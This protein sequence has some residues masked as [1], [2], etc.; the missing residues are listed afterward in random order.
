[1]SNQIPSIKQQIDSLTTCSDKKKYW[2]ET[3]LN[4]AIQQLN[5]FKFVDLHTHLGRSY[6]SYLPKLFLF[7]SKLRN[8]AYNDYQPFPI[9]TTSANWLKLDS[10]TMKQLGIQLG[11]EIQFSW[12]YTQGGQIKQKTKTYGTIEL[13]STNNAMDVCRLIKACEKLGILAKVCNNSY[14]GTTTLLAAKS[15]SC[16]YICNKT[17]L[18]DTLTLIYNTISIHINNHIYLFNL[19]NLTKL[20]KQIS[21]IVN[22]LGEYRNEC[23]LEKMNYMNTYLPEEEILVFDGKRAWSPLCTFEKSRR[24]EYLL[25]RFGKKYWEWDRTAC[26]PNLIYSLNTGKFNDNDKVDL[27]SLLAGKKLTGQERD[28]FKTLNMLKWFG[29]GRSV[30]G[31]LNAAE[32]K[33]KSGKGKI[34][35]SQRNILNALVEVTHADEHG[36]WKLFKEQALNYY[37]EMRN[38][39]E[40]IL[41][42]M[43]KWKD[44]IFIHESNIHIRFVYALREIGCDVAEV[45][46]GF[47]FGK[48]DRRIS[49]KSL[50]KLY[51]QIVLNYV[52]EINT[53]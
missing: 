31:I 51:K 49:N 36:S 23:D 50:N 3:K 27:H 41:G 38:R 13:F 19:T 17:R 40:E 53:K 43:K 18:I 34:K 22:K 28:N 26:I 8:R 47:Y 21:P 1:M 6:K 33:C 11:D 14:I 16:Y 32:K 42:P 45:Y 48:G 37:K 10:R 24:D 46:D 5:N 25:R 52:K 4:S 44:E 12:T 2:T 15:H 29:D 20:K 39:A 7:L 35:A 9:I 30:L